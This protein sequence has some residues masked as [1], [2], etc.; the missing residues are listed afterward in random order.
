MLPYILQQQFQFFDRRPGQAVID[1]EL[2][3]GAVFGRVLW[4]DIQTL[5]PLTIQ[6]TQ[7]IYSYNQLLKWPAEE[8]EERDSERVVLSATERS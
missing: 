3:D 5:S 2:A 1:D 7:L 4:V 6:L 8:R